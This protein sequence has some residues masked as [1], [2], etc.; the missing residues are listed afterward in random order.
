M[1]SAFSFFVLFAFAAA[2][3]GGEEDAPMWLTFDVLNPEES[4]RHTI[5]HLEDLLGE[6]R[7]TIAGLPEA[8]A[9]LVFA[10]TLDDCAPKRGLCSEVGGLAREARALG[11]LVIGVLLETQEA[12]PR[13]EKEIPSAGHP[14]IVAKDGHGIT[15]RA[16]SLDRPGEMV[17]IHSSGRFVRFSQ[18]SEAA[19]EAKRNLEIVRR[20]FLQA[21]RRDDE[22]GP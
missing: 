18:S 21:L 15:R 22:E 7:R 20:A 11:G 1:H 4:G 13:A 6:K 3:A 16:L 19:E 9:V 8:R 12:L 5:L 17:V 2:P 10:V 14:F